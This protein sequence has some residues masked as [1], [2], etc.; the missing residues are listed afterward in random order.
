MPEH[1]AAIHRDR[2]LVEPLE[3]TLQALLGEG[4]MG[5]RSM[6][7]ERGVGERVPGVRA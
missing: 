2:E 5:A 7:A 3:V 1:R 6:L 4:R